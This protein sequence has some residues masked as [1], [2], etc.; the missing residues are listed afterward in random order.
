MTIKGKVYC[1]FEQ[2]GTF[3]DQFRQLGYVAHDYDIA[4]NYGQTDF[5]IDL[6]KEIDKACRPPCFHLKNIFNDITPDDLIIAFFPCVYFSQVNSLMFSGTW[7][8]FNG[9]KK[10]NIINYLIDRGRKRQR[11]YE[12]I[13]KLC[14]IC[15]ERKLRLIVE[16]PNTE[17]HFLS[18]NFPYKPA[19][20]DF[21]RRLSG[22]VFR[23]PTKYYFINCE[24]TLGRTYYALAKSK[25]K[26]VDKV[27]G[28]H[29]AGICDL[30]RSIISAEYAR[31]FICDHI[32]GMQESYSQPY[33]F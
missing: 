14:Y 25:W 22:D 11:Y 7:R 31:H 3:R 29:G 8:G 24:P 10:R 5:V 28:H 9:W 15:D 16:N 32:L 12:L 27:P 33:L 13:L 30:E 4:D 6:F 26:V 18:N 21:N 1:F 2:S 19:I 20:I 23:K 17:P